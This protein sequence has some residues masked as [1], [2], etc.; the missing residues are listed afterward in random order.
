MWCHSYGMHITLNLLLKTQKRKT[1]G[2]VNEYYNLLV[3]YYINI[4]MHASCD[5]FLSDAYLWE[6]RCVSWY[7]W[8]AKCVSC[9]NCD[10]INIMSFFMFI[11]SYNDIT[12]TCL[13]VDYSHRTMLTTGE[14]FT[15]SEKQMSINIWYAWLDQ[16]KWIYIFVWEFDELFLLFVFKCVTC[17]NN[18]N[19][20][21]GTSVIQFLPAGTMYHILCLPAF[22]KSRIQ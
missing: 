18:Y 21:N 11:T 17:C 20:L 10:A 5:V 14:V 1:F 2:P 15:I 7:L 19:N 16:A 12:I 13:R 9:F 3:C 8:E 6:A 4:L 22:E